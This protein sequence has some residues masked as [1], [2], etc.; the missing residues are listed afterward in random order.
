MVDE[1]EARES[2]QQPDK[3]AE[4]RYHEIC[5]NIRALDEN[6]F[7]LL[8]FVPL[9]SGA[10]IVAVIAKGGVGL[11]P[12]FLLGV[13][14]A[15]VTFGLYR[16][17]R[18]NIQICKWLQERADTIEEHEFHV[19]K[20]ERQFAIRLREKPP[21]FKNSQYDN[22]HKLLGHYQ[23]TQRWAETI[24]YG[25]TIIGWLVIPLAVALSPKLPR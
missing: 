4:V 5:A 9:L 6:S 19:K 24:I 13:V 17:E 14:G 23:I 12:A 20:E 22:M 15:L 1:T 25:A 2:S 16:W 7:R 3:T 8:G 18:R 10:A 11:L 21:N